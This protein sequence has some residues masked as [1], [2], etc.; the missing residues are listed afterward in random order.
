VTSFAAADVSTFFADINTLSINGGGTGAVF[1]G[2]KKFIIHPSYNSNTQVS[3]LLVANW[4][5]FA[6]LLD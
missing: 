3:S 4:L 1:R 5:P 6:L 2:V